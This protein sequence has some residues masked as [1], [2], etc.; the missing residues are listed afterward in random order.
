MEEAR[1]SAEGAAEPDRRLVFGGAALASPRS[2]PGDSRWPQLPGVAGAA[3]ITS[4]LAGLGS[5]AG[6]GMTAG[7]FITAG[8]GAATSLL[9]TN[10]LGLMSALR[11]GRRSSRSTRRCWCTDGRA[12][13]S[14][15]SAGRENSASCGPWRRRRLGSTQP[16][17][18]G[19]EEQPCEGLGEKERILQLAIGR[20]HELSRGVAGS[21]AGRE[22]VVLPETDD[23]MLMVRPVGGSEDETTG[24]L[25]SLEG[26]DVEPATFPLPDP[27]EVG[28][29]RSSRLLRD[30]LRLGFRASAGP[31]RSFGRIA[32]SPRPT[33]WC[34]C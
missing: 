17:T 15:P 3:F 12:M 16:S 19:A 24:L 30:A 32:V 5:L 11:P 18:R 25:L 28:D 26:A 13:T 1:S 14:A 9:A 10:A 4:G 34:R 21:C 22:W 23:D 27:D 33:S 20:C 8:A 31:F 6:G 7:L 2:R 29:F